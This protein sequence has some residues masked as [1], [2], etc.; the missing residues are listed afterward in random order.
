VLPSL[1]LTKT[2]KEENL[3][4]Y[5]NPTNNSIYILTQ[6]DKIVSIF[7]TEGKLLKYIEAYKTGEEI[8]LIDLKSGV[9]I[10]QIQGEQSSIIRK[11]IKL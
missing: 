6:S 10:V 8:D 1:S 11:I 7:N 4:I 2:T 3:V 5:P 9:F